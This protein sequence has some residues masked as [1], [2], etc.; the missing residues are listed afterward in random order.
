MSLASLGSARIYTLPGALRS[1]DEEAWVPVP[2]QHSWVIPYK[3]FSRKPQGRVSRKRKTGVT[4]PFLLE[5][6]LLLT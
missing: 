1:R 4:R 2:A 6:A 5:T 3:P